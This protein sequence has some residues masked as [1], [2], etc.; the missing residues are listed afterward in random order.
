MNLPIVYAILELTFDPWFRRKFKKYDFITSETTICIYCYCN[1]IQVI[2][3]RSRRKLS[4]NTSISDIG[5]DNTILKG[6]LINSFNF[7]FIFFNLKQLFQ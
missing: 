3:Y 7:Y 4:K 1:I 5:E 2:M 6:F